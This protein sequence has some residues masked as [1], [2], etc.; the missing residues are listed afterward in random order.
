M[1]TS[2]QAPS[3]ASPKLWL[4]HSLTGVRCRATSVAKNPN[5]KVVW[6]SDDFTTLWGWNKVCQQSCFLSAFA[7]QDNSLEENGK[8]R[9]KNLCLGY[10]FLGLEGSLFSSDRK[11]VCPLATFPLPHNGGEDA[12]SLSLG[13]I[14]R[15]KATRWM[16]RNG[17]QNM[18]MIYFIHGRACSCRNPFLDKMNDCHLCPAFVC[19]KW[20]L[21]EFS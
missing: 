18:R 3:Y 16:L 4:N 13:N 17:E 9:I 15:G 5:M 2:S 20:V 7:K 12:N 14:A 19:G 11:P 8:Q 21:L 1:Q 6:P 10:N